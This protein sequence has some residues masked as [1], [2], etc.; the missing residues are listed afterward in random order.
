[1]LD[2][3][4]GEAISTEGEEY[5]DMMTAGIDQDSDLSMPMPS[6]SQIDVPA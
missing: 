6:S 1:V 3:I 2:G 5:G 4:K